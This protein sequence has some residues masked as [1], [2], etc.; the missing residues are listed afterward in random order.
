M[1]AELPR[2]RLEVRGA[3][4][5]FE[6]ASAEAR[7]GARVVAR[8]SLCVAKVVAGV[9]G[10]G[11]FCAIIVALGGARGQD[12]SLERDL[13]RIRR[14]QESLRLQEHQLQEARLRATLEPSRWQTPPL[15]TYSFEAIAPGQLGEVDPPK[16]ARPRPSKPEA[17]SAAKTAAKAAA[18]T[19]AKAAKAPPSPAAGG[20]APSRR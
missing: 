14:I 1:R 18:K 8:A 12:R 7:Q 20:K 13:E 11:I 9:G 19:A 15:P 5:R 16:V 6:R 3:A 2:A 10:F 17:K 4:A